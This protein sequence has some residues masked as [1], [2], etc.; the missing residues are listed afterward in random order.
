MNDMYPLRSNAAQPG[1]G[2]MA[3]GGF[4]LVDQE[5]A[6]GTGF[7][8]TQIF[9]ALRRHL[10][11]IAAITLSAGL[12]GLIVTLLITPQY[13][14]TAR[15]QVEQE[16]ARVIE[17]ADVEPAASYQDADRFLR[18]Q[19]DIL[20]SRAISIRVAQ[21]LRLFGNRAFVA[22][23]QSKSTPAALS[24][25]PQQQRETVLKLLQSNLS[26]ELP[27]QSRIVSVNFTS[28]DP[29]LSARIAN[30]YIDQF[31]LA[32]LQRKYDSSSYARDFLSKQL[33]E[34]KAKLEASER[35]VNQYARQAGLIRTAE[36]RGDNT[37]GAAPST[38]LTTASLTQLN[39]AAN[40]AQAARIEAEE[41]WRSVANA[42]LLSI[43][44]VISNNALQEVLQQRS[45]AT[46]NLKLERERRLPEYPTVLQLT[47][48]VESL[49]TQVKAIGESI[50]RSIYDRY[51]AAQAQEA[52]L[53]QRVG[54]YKA[55]TLSEQDRGVQYNI[56]SREA[57]TNRT[58][59]EGLLQRFKELSASAGIATNNLSIIDRAEP[60]TAP[61]SP[62]I[63]INILMALVGGLVL[64]VVFV[65]LREQIDDA[66]RVP[67]DSERK[68]QLPLLGVVPK[69]GSNAGT[70]VQ[71]LTDAKSG[72]SEAYNALRTS[73][74]HSTPDGLPQTILM[75]SSQMSEGKSTSAYALA[76][77][78]ARLQR[79]TVLIDVDLRRPSVHRYFGDENTSGTSDVLTAAADLETVMRPTPIDNLKVVFSG[80]IPPN[81]SELLGSVRMRELLS[82]LRGVADVVILDGP[83]TLGLA[84]APLLASLAEGTVFVVEA[85][86]G[87]R[88]GI[89]SAL[90]RLRSTNGR[91]L[92]TLLTKFDPKQAGSSY[93][94][95]GYEYYRYG[96]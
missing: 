3:P 80:P 46:A 64:A 95:Y 25:T 87:R 54:A 89:R 90:R 27:R 4:V 84:D 52:A 10:V 5:E 59:Y 11:M 73:L 39:T 7:D 22:A 78:M 76:C 9:A 77:A 33:G 37:N 8:V 66:I 86:R 67:E 60:P 63:F 34:T 12:L 31:I 45:I 18:T 70:M 91:M 21:A 20:E 26:V 94:Y 40:Q 6:G 28:P 53:N 81:P 48:Q 17:S 69:L 85:N 51:R 57:D 49:D 42:P 35:A 92:G 36:P 79:R 44:E 61:S 2:G 15:V 29:A 96:E 75:T 24:G 41:K 93:N 13:T 19:T 32:N 65:F 47:A 83:P 43:P 16:S 14:A 88:G 23:M 62:R 82:E 30:G 71:E 38:S 58:L 72:V 56:L 74:I 1:N 55:S 68:L 50:K